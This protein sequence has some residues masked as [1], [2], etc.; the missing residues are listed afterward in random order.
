MNAIDR[1]FFKEATKTRIEALADVC[2]NNRDSYKLDCAVDAAVQGRP[3]YW[4]SDSW[5]NSAANIIIG[6]ANLTGSLDEAFASYVKDFGERDYWKIIHQLDAT[7]PL[8]RPAA[9]EMV[10][11]YSRLGH[12]RDVRELLDREAEVI[13]NKLSRTA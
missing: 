8:N 12:M 5:S 6:R 7:I 4:H 1:K 11:I 10:A 9:A 2:R 13:T 3:A